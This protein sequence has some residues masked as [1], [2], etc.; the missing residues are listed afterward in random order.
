MT[1]NNKTSTDRTTWEVN[2]VAV[3]STAHMQ[4]SDKD[5]LETGDQATVVAYA[6][7]YGFFVHLSPEVTESS[8]MND[9]FSASFTRIYFD[10]LDEGMQFV[11]FD[12]DGLVYDDYRKFDW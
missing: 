5:K 8:L 7:E 4:E 6:Y 3:F 1:L 9:G 2:R 11:R 10:A 12:C